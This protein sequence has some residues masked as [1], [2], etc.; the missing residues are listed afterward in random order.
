MANRVWEAKVNRFKKRV[1]RDPPPGRKAGKIRK[2]VKHENVFKG[3]RSVE[4]KT[5]KRK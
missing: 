2:T 5:G 3:K 1:R 4:E